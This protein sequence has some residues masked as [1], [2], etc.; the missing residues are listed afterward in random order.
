MTHISLAILACLQPL[1]HRTLHNH[2][3][4]RQCQCASLFMADSCHRPSY[5]SFRSLRH[6]I[7]FPSLLLARVV[8]PQ[9]LI[10]AFLLTL[11]PFRYLTLLALL[12]LSSPVLWFKVLPIS[13]HFDRACNSHYVLTFVSALTHGDWDVNRMKQLRINDPRMKYGEDNKRTREV[14]MIYDKAKGECIGNPKKSKDYLG[15]VLGVLC[16]NRSSKLYPTLASWLVSC[17]AIPTG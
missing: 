16:V 6:L 8:P 4:P 13:Q 2:R 1:S 10:P 7:C 17:P 5:S 9:P 15:L 14:N 3:P 12:A 11:R